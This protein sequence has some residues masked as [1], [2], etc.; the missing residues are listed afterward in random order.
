MPLTPSQ[1]NL[2]ITFADTTWRM[3]IPTVLMAGLGIVADLRFDTAPWLTL[4]GTAI[5]FAIAI[6]LVKRQLERSAR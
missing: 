4:V 2:A 6:R 5:G 3:T 1:R